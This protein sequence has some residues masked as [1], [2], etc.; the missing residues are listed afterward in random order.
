MKISEII[1]ELQEIFDDCE[2]VEVFI[3]DNYYSLHPI[4][5]IYPAVVGDGDACVIKLDKIV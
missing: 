2:D 3:E 1:K 4:S 5:V